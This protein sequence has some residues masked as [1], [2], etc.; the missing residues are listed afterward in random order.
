[1][2]D[3]SPVI[4]RWQAPFFE[5]PVE[6]DP[7]KNAAELEKL[8]HAK[9]FQL[10]KWEGLEAGRLEAEQLAKRMTEIV[11]EMAQPFRSLDQLV[12]K[13]LAQLAMLIA[14]QVLRRE[15]SANSEVITSIASEALKTLSS[16]D[17]EIEVFL[18]PADVAAVQELMVESM[19]GKSWRLVE[20]S[21]LMPGGCK[22][23]TPMSYVDASIEK[24]LELVFNTMLE[25]SES[26]LDY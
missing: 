21:D 10:G 13:E 16:R 12:A 6:P 14:K 15:L 17:G 26:T 20:D 23:K 1:L 11:A 8:A 25:A 7:P 24:Q 9:G 2:S 18:N 4:E 22:V 19:D 3:Q 5:A